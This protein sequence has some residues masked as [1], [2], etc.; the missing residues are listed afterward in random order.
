MA[1]RL[2]QLQKNYSERPPNWR[3]LRIIHYP[4][5]CK[6]DGDA[7][8]ITGLEFYNN[9]QKATTEAAHLRLYKEYPNLYEAWDLYEQPANSRRYELEARILARQSFQ[10][11]AI[12]MGI[13]TKDIVYYQELFFN[14]IDRLDKPGYIIN[15]AIGD[16]YASTSFADPIL[17]KHFGYWCGKEILDY[18]IYKKLPDNLLKENT[19]NRISEHIKH[20]LE[21]LV[22]SG[23]LSIIDK[24]SLN[25]VMNSYIKLLAIRKD[26]QKNETE[27]DLLAQIGNALANITWQT[28]EPDNESIQNLDELLES[29]E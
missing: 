26:A 8:L 21:L 2:V 25:L 10:D 1:L 13:D 28:N 23:A 17:W 16:I 4:D 14:V 5:T 27:A 22:Q 9:L 20:R 7:Y 18:L 29:E 11:I 3:W 15:Y 24:D 12:T 6:D 19:D